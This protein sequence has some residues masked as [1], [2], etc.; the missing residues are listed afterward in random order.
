MYQVEWLA[1]DPAPITLADPEMGV[2]QALSSSLAWLGVSLSGGA[3]VGCSVPPSAA[4][5]S[6][7]AA[8]MAALQSVSTSAATS[9]PPLRPSDPASAFPQVVRGVTDLILTM[10]SSELLL[11]SAAQSGLVRA[12]NAELRGDWGCSLASADSLTPPSRATALRRAPLQAVLEIHNPPPSTLLRSPHPAGPP[13]GYGARA[14]AGVT[15]VPRLLPSPIPGLAGPSESGTMGVPY[16]LVPSPRGALTSLRAEPLPTETDGSLQLG[17]RPP[18]CTSQQ[19]PT[20]LLSDGG[21]S[22]GGERVLISVKAVG[23]NFRDVLNV[24]GVGWLE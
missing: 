9:S 15:S 16:R 21:C 6:S 17:P 20:G 7:T 11:S 23:I 1:S 24:R 12:F 18:S 8:L 3:A 13:D 5:V 22:P 19:L 14:A 4:V 2:M 10:P